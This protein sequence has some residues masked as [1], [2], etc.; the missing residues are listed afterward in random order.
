MVWPAQT[1]A[2]KAV[3][4]L[5]GTALGFV[6]GT[7]AAFML[8]FPMIDLF[9]CDTFYEQGCEPH[10]NLKLFGSLAA[11]GL[12]GIFAGWGAADLFNK[13]V[14]KLKRP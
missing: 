2:E 11:S 4:N 9:T 1:R 13:L 8:V 12:G 14:G 10:H 5:F 3:R 6:V 7:I